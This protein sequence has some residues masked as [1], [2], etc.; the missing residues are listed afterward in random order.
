MYKVNNEGDLNNA[1]IGDKIDSKCKLSL[2][3]CY[4][5]ISYLTDQL[6]ENK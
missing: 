3:E 6:N 2:Y 5:A 4:E 1:T